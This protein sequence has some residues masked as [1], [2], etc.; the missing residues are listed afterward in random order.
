[1]IGRPAAVW[2]CLWPFGFT[3]REKLFVVLGGPARRGVD[4][5]RRHSRLSQLPNGDMYFNV[6]FVV[7]LVSLL[8]QGWTTPWVARRL[9]V[10]LVNPAPAVQ[11]VE[12]DLPGQLEREMVGYPIL[13]GSGVLVE[14]ALPEW[15]R[16]AL[17]VRHNE[18]LGPD[19]AG[20]LRPGDYAYFLV[21]PDRV[22]RLDRLFSPERRV[23]EHGIFRFSGDI[24]IGELEDLYGL[25]HIEERKQATVADI[26]ADRFENEVRLGDRVEVGPVTLIC[27]EVE[28]DRAKTVS[29]L[30]AET[31]DTGLD[32][33][34]TRRS[35]R[36][37]RWR[38][39][40]AEHL[41]RW[42][43]KPP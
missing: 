43:G 20:A 32:L 41:A 7:V 16:C 31:A 37:R 10:A 18:V 23:V 17:V 26:F 29:M 35:D 9:G 14:G 36:L 13:R 2:A 19:Q 21:P 25:P 39:K 4:L 33:V 28:L 3:R 40:A 42:R 27:E 12:I 8:V 6:A 1:M 34:W 5:P 15:A 24:K 38:G 11:R 30:I 22:L